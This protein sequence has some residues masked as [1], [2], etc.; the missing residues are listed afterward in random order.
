[1]IV[2]YLC[3]GRRAIRNAGK[4]SGSKKT[5][6]IKEGKLVRIIS[7]GGIIL[8]KYDLHC[9]ILPVK[10]RRQPYFLGEREAFTTKQK[11]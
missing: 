4:S 3:Q 7:T 11:R 2:Q 9:S 5:Q 1:M 8:T 10:R 6:R